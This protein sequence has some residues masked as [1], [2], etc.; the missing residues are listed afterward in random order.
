MFGKV[1]EYS[2]IKQIFERNAEIIRIKHNHKVKAIDC[3]VIS[4]MINDILR[5]KSVL[6]IEDEDFI[7]IRRAINIKS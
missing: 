1:K 3:K 4:L 7:F 2:T 6:K 5:H